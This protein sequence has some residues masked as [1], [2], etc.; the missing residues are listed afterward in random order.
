M[1]P[2]KKFSAVRPIFYA[3]NEARADGVLVRVDSHLVVLFVRTD[4]MMKGRSLPAALR[5]L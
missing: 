3:L 1:K 4:P 2:L 5:V